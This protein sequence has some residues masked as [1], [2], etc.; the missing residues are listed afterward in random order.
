MRTVPADQLPRDAGVVVVG[1]GIVG[2]AVA[3]HLTRAGVAGVVLVERDTFATAASGKPIGGLRAR[4]SDRLNALLALRSLEAYAELAADMDHQ[5]VGYLFL[6]RGT[7]DVARF[8]ASVALQNAIGIP[9]VMLDAAEARARCPAIDPAAFTAAAFSPIDGHARPQEVAW[10]Y[11]DAARRRGARF[12][13]GCEVTGIDV[14]DGEIAAVRTTHGVVRTSTV[15]CAAGAWSREIGAMAGVELDV[16]P[17]RRQIAITGPTSLATPGLPFTIDFS[18]SFYFHGAG[19]GLLLGMSDP[20]EVPGFDAAYE[21]AWEPALRDAAA[22]C[23]PG[24]AHLP[25]THG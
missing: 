15:V 18:T 7:E 22:R 9:S 12:V 25:I 1:G 20:T 2:A 6:L 23:A 5:R 11:A 24:V 17:L 16:T 3:F 13:T 14:R 4:F 19:D 10:A 21:S 8:E